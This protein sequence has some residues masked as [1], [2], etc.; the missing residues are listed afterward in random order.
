GSYDIFVAKFAGADGSHL[1]SKR[2]GNTGVDVGRGVAV[3]TG[4]NVLATGNFQVSVD[5]GG[6]TLTAL[7][8]NDIFVAKLSGADGSHL[9]SK[10]FGAA[11]GGDA[12]ARAIALDAAGNP[13]VT[14]FFYLTVDFGGGPLTNADGFAGGYDIF[15]LKL[16]H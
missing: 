1:W 9:W 2:F 6:G 4:G 12:Q 13:F 16:R 11:G 10:S 14:G 3:D 7:G 8:S 5:F 15:F